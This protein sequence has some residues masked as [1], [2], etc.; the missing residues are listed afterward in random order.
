MLLYAT[1]NSTV[2][3]PPTPTTTYRYQR[4]RCP[5][6]ALYGLGLAAFSANVGLY[7]ITANSYL[8]H[9][10]PAP[11]LGRVNAA[12]MWVCLG[13]IPLGALLGGALGSQLGLRT[14]LWICV[15]GTWS[16]SLF[17]LFSPLRTM[18]DMPVEGE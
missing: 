13:V 17:V 15:L 4:L 6:S 16:A 18:R 11:L 1:L 8:Q 12:F 14:T 5:A 10:T 7:N 2:K 3:T 9:I